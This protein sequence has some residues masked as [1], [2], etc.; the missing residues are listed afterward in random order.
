MFASPGQME[1][2]ITDFAHIVAKGNLEPEAEV[3]CEYRR[4]SKC[5][6]PKDSSQ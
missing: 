5:R 1:G 4:G 6:R 2:P 3:L